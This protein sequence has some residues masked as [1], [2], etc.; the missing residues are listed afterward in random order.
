[1]DDKP[2]SIWTSRMYCSEIPRYNRQ[3]TIF[4]NFYPHPLAVKMCGAKEIC[5][6]EVTLTEESIDCYWGWWGKGSQRFEHV[7][8]RKFMVEMC[9]PYGT[10]IEIEKGKGNLVPV[11]ITKIGIAELK[12]ND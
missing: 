1:M 12:L 2:T 8:P 6:V 7:Y 10:D 9:F 5:E 11:K 4:F 3:G